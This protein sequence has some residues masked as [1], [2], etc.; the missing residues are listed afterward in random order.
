MLEF[1]SGLF[2]TSVAEII[3]MF[4]V[5]LSSG[6]VFSQEDIKET[7]D[8]LKGIMVLLLFAGIVLTVIY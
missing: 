6:L 8:A 5:F 1:L 7:P 4:L 2:E 3:G